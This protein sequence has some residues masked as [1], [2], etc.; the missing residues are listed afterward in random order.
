MQMVSPSCSVSSSRLAAA[1]ADLLQDGL[2][3]G[4]GGGRDPHGF[5]AGR[6]LEAGLEVEQRLI[7]AADG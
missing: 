7:R 1:R 6:L 3:V 4:G 5:E 2:R